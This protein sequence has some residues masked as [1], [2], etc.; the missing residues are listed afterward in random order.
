[1]PQEAG[2]GALL[3][4]A[5]DTGASLAVHAV[6][7]GAVAAL[8]AA[9]AADKGLAAAVPMRIEHAMVLDPGLIRGLAESGLPVVVQPGFIPAIGH[10]LVVAPLP[11][12]MLLMPFRSMAKAGIPLVISSDHPGAGLEPWGNVE[13]AV[14]R[15]DGRDQVILP[16]EA[17]DVQ[18]A[19]DAATRQASLV[20]G[21]AD[22]GTL[23]PGSIADMMWCDRDPFRAPA[24]GIGSTT[25]LATW[26][27]GHLAF[28]RA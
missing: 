28:E 7:N 16:D 8:L 11:K 6:G 5:A 23:T 9:R 14:I 20:L 18:T 25:V 13:A 21:D 17:L 3:R 24:D 12:P 2:F 26:S 22:A 27:G 15:R 4:Q 1:M 10:E 19:F